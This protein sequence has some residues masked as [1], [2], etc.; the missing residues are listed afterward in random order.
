MIFMI[1]DLEKI[2]IARLQLA[3]HVQ[4]SYGVV[5]GQF[6][7]VEL[8]KAKNLHLIISSKIESDIIVKFSAPYRDEKST[9]MLE[10]LRS[11]F[12]E[13]YVLLTPYLSQESSEIHST[14]LYKGIPFLFKITTNKAYSLLNLIINK[15]FTDL[16]ISS[17]KVDAVLHINK[18]EDRINF[19]FYEKEDG[20]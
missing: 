10:S 19:S 11:L 17:E 1:N 13:D 18:D 14:E 16:L 5:L 4:K 7:E 2:E 8:Q 9:K 12:S 15:E 20:V 3:Q 6:E